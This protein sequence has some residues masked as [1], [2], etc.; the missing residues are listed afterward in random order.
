[1]ANSKKIILC[2]LIVALLNTSFV[3]PANA[4][5]D[6]GASSW[7]QHYLKVAAEVA[8]AVA[9]Q[10]LT[11]TIISK[12]KDSGPDG[13]PAFIQNWINFTTKAQYQGEAVFRAELSNAK[14]CN[15]FSDDI[16][17]VFGVSPT[18]SI[19]IAGQN[20]RT[21][22]LDS[23]GLKTNCTMPSSFNVS[24]YQKDFSGNG[25]WAAFSRMLEPQNNYY[26]T[27]FTS[28]DE[29]SA[30]RSLSEKS[31]TDKAK[32]GGGFLGFGEKDC[33]LRAGN[34]CVVLGDI[35]TPGS[36]V[37]NAV[38]DAISNPSKFL[39]SDKEDVIVTTAIQ[40]LTSWVVNK[41]FDN[42][43][44]SEVAGSSSDEI[45]AQAPQRT[46]DSYKQEFCMA[47]DNMSGEAGTWIKDNYPQAWEDFSPE[48]PKCAGHIRTSPK[49]A[50]GTFSDNGCGKSY[51]ELIKE[52][53]DKNLYP[54]AR[55]TESCM[56]VVAKPVDPSR[57]PGGNFVPVIKFPTPTPKTPPS[58]EFIPCDDPPKT[59][60]PDPMSVMQQVK[61]D[62]PNINLAIEGPGPNT[63]DDFTAIVAWRLYKAD[64]N[65]GRK[66]A[67][68]PQSTDTLGYLRTDIG[69]GRFEAID[70][71]HSSGTLQRGCYGVVDS[72]QTWIEP[73]PAP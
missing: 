4:G 30:Q 13:G 16:K 67:G 62:F 49:G 71:V 40:A 31:N 52:D 47:E 6:Y 2:L 26:G 42:L 9:I 63:R 27:L 37:G 70:L 72:S 57:L 33:K 41:L 46:A 7:A 32:A 24:N 21:G 12:I 25:G 20:V 50:P 68:G 5:S 44:T 51:C 45:E 28:L 59:T 39:A 38:N 14:L 36:I 43:L 23:Y 48:Q 34:N 18:D 53:F 17:S 19:S 66:R 3:R 8:A 10:R 15:Y 35:K 64:A 69:P 29:V 22:S 11:S 65:W 1:M 58:A 54:Y 73:S 55:C 56:K 60:S 61:K